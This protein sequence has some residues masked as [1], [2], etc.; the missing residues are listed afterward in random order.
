M[1]NGERTI[2]QALEAQSEAPFEMNGAECARLYLGYIDRYADGDT[3]MIVHAPS[4][5]RS[6]EISS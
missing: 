4:P 5:T 2:A 3:D 1:V 6:I